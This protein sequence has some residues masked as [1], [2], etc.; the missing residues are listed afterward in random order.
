[1]LDGGLLVQQ[2]PLRPRKE[3]EA[4]RDLAQLWHWR[5]RTTQLQQRG[6]VEPPADL[7]F[8]EIISMTANGAL[9]A[10]DIP[11]VIGDDFPAF[12][13]AYAELDS[14]E[15]AIATSI[16]QERHFGLNWLC[17]YSRDW[18]ETPTDT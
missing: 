11:R 8:E 16:A 15:L 14:E 3:I 1:L 9:E 17:G 5:A 6:D 2:P 7:T 18:D 10:G 4:M 12:G 13:K